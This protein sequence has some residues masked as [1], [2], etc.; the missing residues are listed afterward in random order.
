MTPFVRRHA[1]VR[2]LGP[3]HAVGTGLVWRRIDLDCDELSNMAHLTAT[4]EIE[5]ARRFAFPRDRRRYV[6]GRAALRLA[7]AE[8]LERRPDGITFTY[9]E[10]GKPF[11]AD[12]SDWHFNL[13]HC[14]NVGVLALGRADCVGEVGIDVERFAPVDDWQM[15]ALANF[16]AQEC[17]MIDGLAAQ[18]RSRGFLSCWTRKE[19]CVKAI[20][21]GLLVPTADFTV[22]VA[23]EHFT[24]SIGYNG[25]TFDVV[26]ANLPVGD[27][28]VGAI[29]W[30]HGADMCHSVR[31]SVASL[32]QTP[33]RG[34]DPG[35]FVERRQSR[36]NL[37]IIRDAH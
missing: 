35:M 37:G 27:E 11:L 8:A 24:A 21:S 25:A 15:L 6:A 1:S 19:A 26:G 31:C 14:G 2:G 17:Q 16:S 22:A 29:A 7:L 28:C 9:N 34:A 30:C 36:P 18:D 23:G 33:M 5:R 4:D 20:G 13:S 10:H 12:D 32:D 3:W